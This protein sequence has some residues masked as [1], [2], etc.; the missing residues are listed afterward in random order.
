MD[1]NLPWSQIIN[2]QDPCSQKTRWKLKLSEYD[3]DDAYKT[4]KTNVNA[5]ASLR[6]P[7]HSEDNE[8]D[9]INDQRSIQQSDV[10]SSIKYSFYW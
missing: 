5:D 7:I 6:N 8:D 2:H 1:E 4:D 9:D 3:S 10:P